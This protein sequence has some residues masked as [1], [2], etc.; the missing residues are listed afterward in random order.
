MATR[1]AF[2]PSFG[3]RSGFV[4]SIL[5]TKRPAPWLWR[6]RGIDLSSTPQTVLDCGDSVRLT[7]FH[8][9]Q[10]AGRKS[11]GLVVLIHGWEGCHESNYLYSMACTL[12]QAGY[13]VFRLNLRDHGGTHHLNEELFHS[14]RIAEVL[15]AVRAIREL[16][17][18]DPFSMIGFSLGG[19]FSLRVG[20]R[21]PDAGLRPA[22]CIGISPAINP[23]STLKA[24]DDGPALVNRYFLD[25]W[26]KTLDAKTKAWPDRY[27]FSDYL[28]LETFVAITEKFVEDFTEYGTL[29]NYLS[30]Y[31][32][33][34]EILMRS[35]TPLAI[36]TATDDTVIPLHYFDG[37]QVGGSIAAFDV[38]PHGGHCGFIKNWRMDCWAETRVLELL[39]HMR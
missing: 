15:G 32:L 22:L 30:Q 37:L 18:T 20:L 19:N 13:N 25:K 33:T 24:I 3:L 1:P 8:N 27:D 6:R 35:P 11:R 31:T 9:P 29:E 34:P 14:A 10:P 26:A 16:D 17:S 21:G 5:A 28:K 23:G 4:Q 38:V 12:W 36:L 2:R 39:T 7:G